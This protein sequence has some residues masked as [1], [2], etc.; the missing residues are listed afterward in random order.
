MNTNKTVVCSFCFYFGSL[1]IKLRRE[2][3]GSKENNEEAGHFG[4]FEVKKKRY[5]YVCVHRHESSTMTNEE[6][7]SK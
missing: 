7:P 6:K 1:L 3:D 4:G 5:I 2:G